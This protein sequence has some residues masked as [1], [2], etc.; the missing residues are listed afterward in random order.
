[1]SQS[2]DRE[3]I[4]FI[5][6]QVQLVH[7]RVTGNCAAWESSFCEICVRN[8]TSANFRIPEVTSQAIATSQRCAYRAKAL[9]DKG[10]GDFR[11]V[12]DHLGACSLDV[13][14]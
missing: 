10:F 5:F 7:R 3:F 13:L 6:S 1:L 9:L 14:K 8:A 2:K 11:K 4:R 12:G